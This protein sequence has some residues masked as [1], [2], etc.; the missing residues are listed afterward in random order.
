MNGSFYLCTMRVLIVEVG[1]MRLW[2]DGRARYAKLGCHIELVG[3]D[4]ALRQWSCPFKFPCIFYWVYGLTTKRLWGSLWLH[5]MIVIMLARSWSSSEGYMCGYACA[6]LSMSIVALVFLL[7]LHDRE[8]ISSMRV[9]VV[10]WLTSEFAFSFCKPTIWGTHLW[11]M[12]LS[13]KAMKSGL[14]WMT[15]MVFTM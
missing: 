2:I 6:W 5:A 3:S 7:W 13:S 10:L 4:F 9:F 8:H 14:R 1:M 15:V 11:N 12:N